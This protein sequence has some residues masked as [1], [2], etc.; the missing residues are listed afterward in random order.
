[1]KDNNLI[2][3]PVVFIIGTFIITWFCIGLMSKTD[4]NTHTFLFT[5]LDFM[6]NASPLFCALVLFR[7]YLTR[8]KFLCQFFLGKLGQIRSYVIVIILFAV[9]FLNFY[10][11]QPGDAEFSVQT[12]ISVFVGQ[13]LLGG[14]LEEAGWRGYLLPYLYEKHNI[15]LSSIGVSII[16]VLWHLPYFFIPG[17]M[18]AGENF[19]F[20]SVI[21]IVTGFIL[22]AIFLLTKSVL[23]CMLFHSW[24]NA[25]VMTVQADM[26]DIRFILMFMLLGVISVLLCVYRQRQDRAL[27]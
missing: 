5:L 23:L 19:F 9:Q 14:G 26:S 1:M 16:W 21:G 25:I 22:A 3:K 8:E 4:Y 13:F 17:S 12:F 24:Q 15:L 7:Q 11:F 18:Q 10:L 2:Y 20:Y 27:K 6:E